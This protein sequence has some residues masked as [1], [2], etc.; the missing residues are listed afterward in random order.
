MPSR[1]PADLSLRMRRGRQDDKALSVTDPFFV[2]FKGLVLQH[3]YNLADEQTECQIR[4]R[5]SFC[6]FLGM[7]PEGQVPGARWTKNHGQTHCGCKNHISID[8]KHKLIRHFEVTSAADNTVFAVLLDS[9]NT[10]AHVWTDAA[11]RPEA[12]GQPL[13]DAGYRSHIHTKGQA[14]R[15]ISASQQRANR[16]RSKHRCRVEHVFATQHAMATLLGKGQKLPL[17]MTPRVQFLYIPR[18]LLGF[19]GK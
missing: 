13:E 18:R 4:D 1:C 10:S 9:T 19:L 11:C 2:M 8:R 15:P 14:N 16:Q 3:P 5:H 6:R 12:C 17:T 7:T